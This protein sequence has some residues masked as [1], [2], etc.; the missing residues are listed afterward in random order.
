MKIAV[1]STNK[2]KLEAAKLA[3]LKIFPK[4][5]VVG[6]SV[7]SGVSDQPKSDKE[8]I[9]GAVNR[10]RSAQKKTKADFGIGMEGGIQKIGSNWFESGWIAVVDKNGNLGLGSSARFEMSAKLTK[11]LLSG[12][13]LRDVMNQMTNRIDVHETDGAMGVLTAGHLKRAE[14]YSHGIIFAFAPF[15]SDEKFW[16]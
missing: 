15:L 2:A 6:V 4:A 5:K 9:E 12:K 13:E 3:I 11:E 8:S 16:R 10:A 14:A 1:G 7:V